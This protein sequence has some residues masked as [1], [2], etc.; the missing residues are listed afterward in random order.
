MAPFPTPAAPLY[1]PSTDN[2]SNV[3][4]SCGR[5]EG[6]DGTR[7]AWLNTLTRDSNPSVFVDMFWRSLKLAFSSYEAVHGIST[8]RFALDP[9]EIEVSSFNSRCYQMRIPGV[10]NLSRPV[11]GP[12]MAAKG[13]FL[14][15]D[16]FLND[17]NVTMVD[18]WRCAE[19]GIAPSV[20]PHRMTFVNYL[21]REFGRTSN[22]AG[23][24]ATMETYV[25]IH[26]M[27]GVVLD[28]HVTGEMLTTMAPLHVEG[29]DDP[30]LFVPFAEIPRTVVPILRF[31]RH[32]V[33]GDK[34]INLLKIVDASYYI[35]LVLLALGGVCAA[36]STQW[37][38]TMPARAA[39]V[40]DRR[41][42]H[43]ITSE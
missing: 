40:A 31:E 4:D 5:V 37:L 8:M 17:I 41:N 23:F 34:M 20:C 1:T 43:S 7:F 22:P 26:P 42:Y 32:A 14:D 19:S 28:G 39:T 36:L 11:Y 35:A 12:A 6:T 38:V 2:E 27:T 9:S 10:F 29:C 15:A 33:L 24:R 21:E 16:E 25:D 18:R 13:G 30:T 3:N